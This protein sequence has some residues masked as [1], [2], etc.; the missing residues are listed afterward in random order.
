LLLK[1]KIRAD[2][3]DARRAR[4]KLRT[5]LLTTLLSDIRNREIEVGR[6][7]ADPDVIEV[8]NRSVKRRREASEQMRAGNRAELAD[9]EDA[10]AVLL[11][12]YLPAQ[13]SEA[14]VRG[15]VRD[16][17]AE[18]AVN[19]GAVM[20]KVMPRIKGAFDGKEANRIVQEELGTAG[21][22]HGQG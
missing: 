11:A 19:V 1:E 13:L 15:Y 9:K 6:D 20:G 17:I 22:G 18:G 5:E 14:E 7:A 2:L 8:V 3:N 4:D 10:E 12:V 21:Q 16:A